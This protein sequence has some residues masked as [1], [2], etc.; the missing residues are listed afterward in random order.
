MN[1]DVSPATDAEFG[2]VLPGL[3]AIAV[4]QVVQRLPV[5]E[6]L[7]AVLNRCIRCR[8]EMGDEAYVEGDVER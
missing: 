4:S 6:G 3:Q 5:I 2:R 7:V 8:K 1:Q